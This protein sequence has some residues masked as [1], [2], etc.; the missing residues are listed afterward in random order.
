MRDRVEEGALESIAAP[1]DLDARRLLVQAIATEPEG[2]LVGRKRQ[3][4]RRLRARG[5]GAG[6]LDRPERA[7]HGPAGLDPDPQDVAVGPPISRPAPRR[8]L[9]SWARR[10]RAGSSPGVRTSAVTMAVLGTGPVPLS[11][12][13]RSRGPP[14][15][16]I[17]TRSRP[18]SRASRSTIEPVTDSVVSAVASSRLTAN[19]PADSVARRSASPR[20]HGRARRDARRRAP[21]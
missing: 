11:E 5:R 10:Q 2:Q 17:Q 19:R 21:R 20:V 15:S 12:R 6:G 13:I 4:P 18:V 3:E 1:R 9:A 16:P 14:S 7:E 8:W